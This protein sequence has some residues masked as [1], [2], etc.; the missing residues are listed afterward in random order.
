MFS[1]YIK[2]NQTTPDKLN[3]NSYNSFNIKTNLLEQ[4][5][6]YLFPK[7]I[8]KGTLK[9]NE[10]LPEITNTTASKPN[11]VSSSTIILD[12]EP[13]YLNTYSSYY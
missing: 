7:E 5:A 12:S 3:I 9:S 11:I 6:K 13:E 8:P 10:L 4:E 2:L 1:N